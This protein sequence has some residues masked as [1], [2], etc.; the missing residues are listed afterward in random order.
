MI[1]NCDD[2]P[3]AV[4]A[5]GILAQVDN[6]K[7]LA[8][9]IMFL[10]I[11]SITKSLSDHLQNEK[12]DMAQAVDLVLSTSAILN[13]FRSDTTKW[14][15]M[16]KYIVDVAKLH[17]IEASWPTKH[18]RRRQTPRRLADSV[19]L[20]STGSRDVP[21]QSNISQHIKCSVYYPVLDCILAEMD[22]RFSKENLEHMKAIQ[23]CSPS[24]D[25]FLNV[26]Y[27][28]PLA[29]TYGLDTELLS[30][31]CLLAKRTLKD[32]QDM[33]SVLDVFKTILPLADAFP[34]LKKVLQIALT[35]V[36]STATCERSFSA[37][38]RIK[39]YLRTTMSDERL[40]DLA[41]L[42]LERDI[43][44]NLDF[45]EIIH[46]FEGTDKNRSIILS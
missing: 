3:K 10:K 17:N 6:F 45:D 11:L 35:M 4:E 26:S 22:R 38:K 18:H 12:I 7:F 21:Q 29:S 33:E 43:S 23:A 40:S 25:Y 44:A 42:S 2:K 1:A 37:L 9:L 27:I 16:Y 31:E 32:G 30:T 13:E 5:V 20:D 15:Q 28:T 36:V 24:S 41:T 39:T 8:H 46:Q 14:E 19:L 34:T